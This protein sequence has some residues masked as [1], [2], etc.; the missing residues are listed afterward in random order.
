VSLS[1]AAS[2]IGSIGCINTDQTCHKENREGK[3]EVASDTVGGMSVIGKSTL[4]YTLQLTHDSGT[5]LG[6]ANQPVPSSRASQTAS[7]WLHMPSNKRKTTGIMFAT[8][9]D[10]SNCL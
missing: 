4:E 2:A 9:Q 6:A 7:A 5:H 1:S 10:R 8:L 3:G